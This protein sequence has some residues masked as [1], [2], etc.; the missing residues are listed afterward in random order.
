MLG[1][2]TLATAII[3]NILGNFFIKKFS[4]GAEVN[5]VL[6]YLRPSFIF[7]VIFFGTGLLLYTRALKEVPV[8][9]AYPI[10]VGVTLTALSALA[11]FVLGE[12]FTPRAALGATLIIAGIVLLSR[13]A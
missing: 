1:W 11:I 3:F 12:R 2:L 5:D 4:L 13:T 9:I 10:M 7:G 6:D 8:T